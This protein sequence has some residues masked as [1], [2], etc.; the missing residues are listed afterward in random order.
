MHACTHTHTTIKPIEKKSR[1]IEF[2]KNLLLYCLLK[3]K[4]TKITNKYLAEYKKKN[5]RTVRTS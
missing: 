4:N 2:K 5:I 3:H 1:F